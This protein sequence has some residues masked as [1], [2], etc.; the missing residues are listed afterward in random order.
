MQLQPP[1]PAVPAMP[2]LP[3]IAPALPPVPAAI[4]NAFASLGIELYDLPMTPE[5]VLE[6]I[7]RRAAASAEPGVEARPR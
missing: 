2:A 7:D 4:G 6:A 1:S 3:P 5:R